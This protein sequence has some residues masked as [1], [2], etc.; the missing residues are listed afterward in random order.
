MKYH[1][2]TNHKPGSI[3]EALAIML[4]LMATAL[5]GNLI[6]FFDRLILAHYSLDAMNAVA[7]ASTAIA[8][9][10]YVIWAVTS[11]SEI[12]VAEAYTRQQ[13]N[14]IVRIV[15]QT[16][17]L[18]LLTLPLIIPLYLYSGQLIIP[19]FY[20]AQGLD[21]YKLMVLSLPIYG[22]ATALDSFF[23]GQG[24]TKIVLFISIAANI[25]NICFDFIFIFGVK[26]I[27]PAFGA[28]GA[29]YSAILSLSFEAII[30]FI[31]FFVAKRNFSITENVTK[32]AFRIIKKCLT[33]GMPMSIGHS[34]EIGAWLVLML[35]LSSVNQLDV[36]MLTIGNSIYLLFAFVADGVSRGTVVIVS[37]L[38]VMKDLTL[39]KQSI[40]STLKIGM[41]ILI[42][43]AIPLLIFPKSIVYMFNLETIMN[44]LNFKSHALLYVNLLGIW[45]FLIF[46]G[47]MWVY[48]SVLLSYR[49]LF[50]N[51]IIVAG[52]VW[53]FAVFPC[54][55]L[56][57]YTNLSAE[58]IWLALACYAAL[59]F[60]FSYW[61]ATYIL[62]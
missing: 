32:P 58:Y 45:L 5:S 37:N 38:R 1:L 48:S 61:R 57:S 26:H 24:K 42:L 35:M 22:I 21:Y 20:Q 34:I 4:P 50:A 9:Y 16:V 8:I 17:Y 28:T 41:T 46:D 25:I 7:I 49:D 47:L 52:N 3:K 12:F 43:L 31:C 54:Y 55:I 40:R 44:S 33:I 6:I 23:V 39:I 15:W 19:E 10:Q 62:R 29:A 13:H 59:N 60:S 2:L 56:F 27:I 30:L 11:T 51:M 14:E 18:V 53:V 36:T